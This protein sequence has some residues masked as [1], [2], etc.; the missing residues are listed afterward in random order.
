MNAYD[1]DGTIYDGDS[2]IDFVLFCM[3]R[4]PALLSHAPT[5]AGA[6]LRYRLGRITKTAMKQMFFSFMGRLDD[7]HGDVASFWD[8]HIGKV[9]AW[10][11]AQRRPDD[12]IISASPEFLLEEACARLGGANLLASRV[13]IET[14]AFD[15]ENCRGAEKV[16][17]FHA[18]FGDAAIEDFYSDSVE[19]DQP[20]AE[21]AERAWLVTG[22]KIEPWP[23]DA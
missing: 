12:L 10:Y 16:R 6:A 11:L 4:H 17:R 7:P 20:M 21:L 3:R 15:G 1:F 13:D 5:I 8:G 18:A 23:V 22:E 14:G 9:K 2:S 19:A